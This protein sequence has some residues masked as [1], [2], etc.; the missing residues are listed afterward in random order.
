MDKANSKY[1]LNMLD[2]I[3]N[4]RDGNIVFSKMVRELEGILDASEIKDEL[5][6]KEWYSLWQPLETQNAI[7]GDETNIQMVLRELET[8]E[9]FIREHMG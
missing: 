2:L 1:C 3:R 6:K 4:Y 7:Y 5:I 8:F 9:V